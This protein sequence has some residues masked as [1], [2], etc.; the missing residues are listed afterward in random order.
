MLKLDTECSCGSQ[1]HLLRWS[2]FDDPSD[3]SEDVVY[4]HVY[5]TNRPWYRRIWIGL[6]Y[7]WGYRSRY[8]EFTEIILETTEIDQLI[9]FLSKKRECKP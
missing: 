3:E 2:Y 8:G 7:M 9:E 6:K 5:L 1:E 4:C